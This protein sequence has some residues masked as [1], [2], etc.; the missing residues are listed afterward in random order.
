MGKVLKKAAAFVVRTIYLIGGLLFYYMEKA[1]G[2]VINYHKK[3]EYIRVGACAK[4]GKCC[5]LLAI[6]YPAFFNRLPRLL[7]VTIAWHQFRYGFT[8]FN[9]EGNYLLYKCS[10][11]R[12]DNTCAIYRFRPRL[13]REYPRVGLYGKPPIHFGCGFY[14]VRRD[15]RLGF[16]ESLHRARQKFFK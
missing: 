4:C 13:C 1:A 2:W 6:Q 15:G 12:R 7:N 11:L 3:T 8:Y 10:F 9:K 14:F 5:Q 16:D